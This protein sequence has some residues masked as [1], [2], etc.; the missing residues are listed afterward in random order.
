MLYYKLFSLK[1]HDLTEPIQPEKEGFKTLLNIDVI[2]V[3]VKSSDTYNGHLSLDIVKKWY[4][5]CSL[6]NC[7][8]CTL[9]SVLCPSMHIMGTNVQIYVVS[10]CKSMQICVNMCLYMHI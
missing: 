7:R 9:V 10:S 1:D 6:T 2:I 5:T 8:K 3:D 4:V